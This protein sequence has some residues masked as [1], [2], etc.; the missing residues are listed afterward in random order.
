MSGAVRC[1]LALLALAIAC[2]G[3]E[4]APPPERGEPA[5]TPPGETVAPADPVE[6]T[7]G[8][9]ERASRAKEP[10]VVR[11]VE[12][13]RHQSF[14][15]VVWEFAGSRLPGIHV[16]YVD[17]PVRECGSGRSVPLPGDGWLEVRFSPARGYGPAGTATVPDSL[18]LD[19]PLVLDARRIC[20][21]EAIHAWVLAVSAPEP[22]RVL[23]LDDPPRFAVDVRHRGGDPDRLR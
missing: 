8:I 6:W 11:R 2:G 5:A 17:E 9:V 3:E 23:A 10:A 20:D 16:E 19:L 22:Y 18:G 13:A 4:P 12:A 14:D 1:S 15:R 7:A 21:F